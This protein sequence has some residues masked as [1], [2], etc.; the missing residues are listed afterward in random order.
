VTGSEKTPNWR[1]RFDGCGGVAERGVDGVTVAPSWEV[2]RDTGRV[3]GYILKNF[4]LGRVYKGKPV[5]LSILDVL[6]QSSDEFV[7]VDAEVCVQRR[8]LH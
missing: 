4:S 2:G 8:R 6:L 1:G 3:E 7:S 5:L